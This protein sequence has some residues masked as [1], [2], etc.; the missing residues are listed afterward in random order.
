[1]PRPVPL[2]DH[3][4]H[5]SAPAAAWDVVVHRPPRRRAPAR[6][7]RHSPRAGGLGAPWSVLR[8]PAGTGARH[9]DHAA[10][11]DIGVS[12][13]ARRWSGSSTGCPRASSSRRTMRAALARRRLGYGR[14]SRAGGRREQDELR[15]LGGLRHGAGRWPSRSRTPSGPSQWPRHVVRTGAAEGPARRRR[16]R[17]RPGDRAQPPAHPAPPGH[18]DLVGMRKYS[19]GA[20]RPCSSAPRHARRRRASRSAAAKFLEQALGVR[21]VSHVVAIGPVEVP[22]DAPVP[23]PDGA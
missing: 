18:A 17:R 14:G 16:D 1:M 3:A 6:G 23:G 12:R 10:L 19:L 5:R 11:V 2:L 13:T 4:R 8:A 20:P 7:P 22:E 9:G 21:L 15:V